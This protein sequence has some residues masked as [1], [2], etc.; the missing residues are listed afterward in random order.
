MFTFIQLAGK[1]W[2]L[3]AGVVLAVVCFG[4]GYSM[5]TD[6][7]IRDNLKASQEF[8]ENANKESKNFEDALKNMAKNRVTLQERVHETSKPSY[9]CIIPANG[10]QQYISSIKNGAS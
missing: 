9:N 8:Q 5:A 4:Y 7:C 3:I 2:Q 6:K 10:V 1:Y